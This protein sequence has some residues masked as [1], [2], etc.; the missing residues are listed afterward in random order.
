MIRIILAAVLLFCAP[1]AL[2]QEDGAPSVIAEAITD[3][4]VRARLAEAEA[5][6]ME[7][8]PAGALDAWRAAYDAALAAAPDETLALAQIRNQLGAAHFYAGEPEAALGHFQAAAAA[9]EG[10][11][12]L[13]ENRQEA[14]GNVGSILSRLG[15]FAEAEAAQREAFAIRRDLYPEAHPQIARSYFELGALANHQGRAEEAARLV[16]RALELRLQVLG[17][18]HP[19]AAMTQVSLA[20]ILT[21]AQRHNEAIEEARG[22]METLERILPDGHPFIGFAQSNYAGA[23][24]AAGRHR[25]AEPFLRQ[26][27]EA[28]RAQLGDNHPQ[29]ADSLNNLAVAV[30]ALGREAEARTLF[31][32]ARDIY[33]EA[34]GEDSPTAARMQANAADFAGAD[35]LDERLA[36][37]AAFDRIGIDGGEDRMRLLSRTAVSLAES[38]RLDDALSRIAEARALAADLFADG[39]EARLALAIDEAWIRA[40]EP[41]QRSTALAL[42]E[43]AA[44][45]LVQASVLD[46]DRSRDAAVRRDSARRRALDVAY[47]AGDE[48]LAVA[49]LDAGG[50]GGLS[51]ALAAA[52]ARSGAAAEALR[53]RQDA[54]RRARSAE[55]AYIRLRASGAG[56]DAVR[57][58]AQRWDEARSELVE[59]DEALPDDLTI[60]TRAPALDALKAGLAP[61]EAALAFAFTAR[62]GVVAAIT[63]AGLTLKRLGLTQ[64]EAE[65]RVAAVRAALTAGAGAFRSADQSAAEALSAFPAGDAHAL[66]R[67]VFSEDIEAAVHDA[68]TLIVKPDGPFASLPFSVLLTSAGPDRLASQ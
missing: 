23:L 34:E 28:R 61:H 41:D 64:D 45:A 32:A 31:L 36:A 1:A 62:G 42:A 3:E 54:A 25:E 68:R 6:D 55:T 37:L 12:D 35:R 20:S 19:Y 16:R 30:G 59:A 53:S 47:A 60:E 11:D 26:I 10:V 33:L 18:D 51:L 40:A 46:V 39:H 4:T 57:A 44:R 15:R 66:Y 58:A 8:D 24:N 65:R 52:S 14:L 67:A 29:V 38:G 27:V 9:F 49:L 48:A 43:P 5:L 21:G 13:A 22:G 17:P 50:P 63:S 7:A 56:E 2:A